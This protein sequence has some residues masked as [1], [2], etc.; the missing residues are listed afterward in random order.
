MKVSILL[1]FFD[2]RDTLPRCIR[3][4]LAQTHADWELLAVDDGSRD[5]SAELI[6][7]FA[8]RRIR[9]FRHDRNRGASAARNT[10]LAAAQG[11]FVA[12]IDSDDE[13]LPSKLE[14][15]L[16]RLEQTGADACG[17]EYWLIT[18]EGETHRRLPEPPSWEIELHAACALGN[19][20]TLCA[21]RAVLAQIGPM[22]ESLRFYEDWDWLLRLTSRFRYTVVP[23][24]LARI[25]ASATR[26]PATFAASAEQFLRLHSQDFARLGQHHLATI[27]SL[28]YEYVAANALAERQF[29]LGCRYVLK[30]VL[31]DP[32]RR[33][34]LLAT[35]LLAPLDALFGTSLLRT[36]SEW[37]RRPKHGAPAESTRAR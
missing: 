32:R 13:W 1:P 27:R 31:A 18:A 19:G 21:R 14:R 3:S 9:V 16:A 34:E 7:G 11:E 15:Q 17:C 5:G 29:A 35:L 6:E 36:V 26:H 33:P 10:A 23:E 4:V 30:S 2:R 25:H 28:H 8:D 20:T 37:S 24:P 22:N 12:L